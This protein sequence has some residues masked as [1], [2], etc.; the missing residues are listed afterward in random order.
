MNSVSDSHQRGNG[1]LT[2]VLI[3]SYHFPPQA[4]SGAIRLAKLAKSWSN[5]GVSVTVISGPSDAVG[6]EDVSLLAELPTS[7]VHE[8]VPDASPW[9][10][11][12]RLREWLRPRAIPFF[13]D[14]VLVAVLW[15][16]SKVAVDQQVGWLPTALWRGIRVVRRFRPNV[17]LV[18]GPPFSSFLVG[19][20]LCR[21]FRIPLVLDYRDP[22]LAPPD[23]RSV[24]GFSRW[25]NSHLERRIAPRS[26]GIVAA[27]R[28]ILREVRSLIPDATNDGPR[29]FWVPNGYDPEDFEDAAEDAQHEFTISYA[30]SFYG[31]RSP[32]VFLQALDE[33]LNEGF[34]DASRFRVRFS[35]QSGRAA[36]SYRS[37]SRLLE[38]VQMEPYR[39][40]RESVRLLQQST[41]NL[42][43]V[44][45][46]AGPPRW[47]PA[48]L[49]ENLFAGRPV[50]LLSPEGA[51][52]QLVRRAGG[53]WIAHPEDREAIKKVVKSLYGAWS[54][55]RL[56]EKPD[57]ARIR[58]FDR[59]HQARRYL[60][61]LES[62]TENA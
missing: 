18:S 8:S 45:P 35:G 34:I 31:T 49:Y 7:V 56:V 22:W 16:C 11:V 36:G 14:R 6:F 37:S 10:L 33:L 46:R 3:L 26:T 23:F 59:R 41:V 57:C 4:S 1:G 44:G 40:H 13:L 48:K 42:V 19:A 51:A 54:T 38:V 29:F 50:L 60:G 20:L 61:F 39:P 2:R 28:F 32:E 25:L 43:V 27:H 30:G 21:L 55:G 53:C 47:V 5:Q 62:T 58:F 52:T 15:A 24:T 9:L 12:R 17:L